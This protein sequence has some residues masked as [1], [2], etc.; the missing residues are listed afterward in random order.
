LQRRV[1]DEAE[2][3]QRQE[4]VAGEIVV[5]PSLSISPSLRAGQAGTRWRARKTAK[6]KRK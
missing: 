2:R 6:A 1:K 4:R 3:D 5:R